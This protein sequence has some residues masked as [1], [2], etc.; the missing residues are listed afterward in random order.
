MKLILYISDFMLPG[1]LMIILI[2]GLLEKVNIF[3]TFIEGA[4]ESVNVIMTIMPTLIGL[5]VAVGIIRASGA[6]DLIERGLKPIFSFTSFPLQLIPLSILR[7]ISS[8]AS[9]GLVL[10]LFKQYGPDSF[11]GRLVSVMM[12]CTETIFYTM[13]VYFMSVG[14]KKT[15]Y[16]LTGAILA[17]LAGIIASFYITLWVF[18]K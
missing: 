15:R 16:T 1:I 18:G 11:I 8:S 6:L 10:D 12:G 17:N 9:L 4:K 2:Y 3:D 5:M 14:I 7:T 13:S